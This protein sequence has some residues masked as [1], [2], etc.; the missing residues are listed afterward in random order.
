MIIGEVFEKPIKSHEATQMPC[1]LCTS[2]LKSDNSYVL[3]IAST[4][5]DE[6]KPKLLINIRVVA[7]ATEKT[8]GGFLKS[9]KGLE[10]STKDS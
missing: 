5:A 9:L 4:H 10:N 7:T 3:Q 8:V 2:S 6:A 1:E